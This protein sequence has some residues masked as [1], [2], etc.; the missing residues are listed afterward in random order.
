MGSEHLFLL[1][2]MTILSLFFIHDK[3]MSQ[4]L[5]TVH[6]RPASQ[7]PGSFN[8][9]MFS[10]VTLMGQ[11]N[12]PNLGNHTSTWCKEWSRV[13]H[14]DNIIMAMPEG[15][16]IKPNIAT[17]SVMKYPNE[18]KPGFVTPYT[19]LAKVIRKVSHQSKGLLYVHD[20]LMVTRNLLQK[21]L[22][23]EKRWIACK[24]GKGIKI[25]LNGTISNYNVRKWS[26]WKFCELKFMKLIGNPQMKTYLQNSE[27]SGVP[28][29][30][31]ELGQ[32]DML[33]LSLHSAEVTDAFLVLLDL[34]GK[35]DLSLEC[36]LPTAV[37]LIQQRFT[38]ERHEA[39][40]CTDFK[41][42][43]IKTRGYTTRGTREMV[44]NCLI[45][46]RT[47]EV[48]HPLKLSTFTD[49][50]EFFGYLV[51]GQG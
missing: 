42:E 45:E 19:N 15:T 44:T 3:L 10:E 9:L 24:H 48:F 26:Y 21:I 7:I 39:L 28:F 33:Y 50:S 17:C 14:K 25:Y 11:F 51:L 13:F 8:K 40:L 2:L 30:R 47:Y 23:N 22:D 31:V 35:Y 37:S 5:T 36:A 46:N 49:W 4:T 32:S 6:Y 27:S 43:G 20:D 38:I 12:Y 18:E 34:F 41:D 16:E 1:S 29:L